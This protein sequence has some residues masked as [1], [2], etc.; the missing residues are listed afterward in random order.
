ME[1]TIVLMLFKQILKR[2]LRVRLLVVCQLVSTCLHP[3]VRYGCMCW[4]TSP[5]T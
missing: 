4:L 5:H 2:R 3:G 1:L